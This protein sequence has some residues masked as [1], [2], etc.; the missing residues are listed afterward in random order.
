[1]PRDEYSPEDAPHFASWLV[2]AR[3]VRPGALS[4]LCQHDADA[5]EHDGSCRECAEEERALADAPW[6]R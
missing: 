3:G 6:H 5:M 4:L 2:L 1:M